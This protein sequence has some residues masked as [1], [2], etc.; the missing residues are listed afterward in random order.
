MHSENGYRSSQHFIRY[1]LTTYVF[2]SNNL[3]SFPR[4]RMLVD[5]RSFLPSISHR[6]ARGIIY[7]DISASACRIIHEDFWDLIFLRRTVYHSYRR[8]EFI[9]LNQRNWLITLHSVRV[10]YDK[11]LIDSF[12]CFAV[13]SL[14][15][16]PG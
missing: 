5:P 16:T 14:N 7:N 4:N 11:L 10:K 12:Q 13:I 9:H 1:H 6:K 2:P 8:A 3:K 15:L